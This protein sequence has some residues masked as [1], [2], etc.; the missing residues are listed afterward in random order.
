MFT[1]LHAVALRRSVSLSNDAVAFGGGGSWGVGF[2]SLVL[3]SVL[4]LVQLHYQL[5]L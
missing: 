5:L 3:I 1:F 2:Q 4:Q